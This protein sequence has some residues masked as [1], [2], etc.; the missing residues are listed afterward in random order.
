LSDAEVIVF[1]APPQGRRPSSI[2]PPSGP[3]VE[4]SLPSGQ[5]LRGRSKEVVGP[6]GRWIRPEGTVETLVF[7]PESVPARVDLVDGKEEN[8]LPPPPFAQS[9]DTAETLKDGTVRPASETA[10]VNEIDALDLSM[11]TPEGD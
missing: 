9:W 1:T 6:P 7:V 5:K 4:I 11:L 3:I 8:H 2:A 10:T